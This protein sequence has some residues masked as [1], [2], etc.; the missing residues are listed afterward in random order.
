MYAN[1]KK[2]GS[3]GESVMVRKVSDR[4]RAIPVW[5]PHET[6]LLPNK[7][8]GKRK[9]RKTNPMATDGCED[10]DALSRRLIF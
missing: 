5:K 6:C 1:I 2:G 10:G 7:H 8:G 9:G 3:S 4:D